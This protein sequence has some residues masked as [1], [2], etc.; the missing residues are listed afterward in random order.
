MPGQRARSG[1]KEIEVISVIPAISHQQWRTSSARDPLR[2]R[3]VAA[4]PALGTA[5][6]VFAAALALTSCAS[7]PTVE[8]AAAAPSPSWETLMAVPATEPLPG[9]TVEALQAVLDEWLEEAGYVGANAAVVSAE[10]VWQGSAGADAE[11]SAL[12]WDSALAVGSIAKTYTAAAVMGLVEDGQVDLDAPIDTYVE[13]PF[14]TD[15]ATVRQVL[16]MRSGFP[17]DRFGEPSLE[18]TVS[19]DLDRSW[20]ID[21]VLEVHADLQ[22]SA[23]ELGGEQ[24]YS[25]LNY[26]ALG[27]LVESVTGRSMADVVRAELMDPAGLERTWWQDAHEP[28]APLTVGKDPAGRTSVDA[29]GPWMPS[30]AWASVLGPA[31]GLASTAADTARWGYLLYGGFLLKPES[32]QQMTESGQPEGFYCDGDTCWYGLGTELSDPAGDLNAVGHGGDGIAYAAWLD[33]RQQS[34]VSIALLVPASWQAAVPGSRPLYEATDS[35]YE[36]LENS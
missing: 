16:N 35:L 20:S 33:V 21:E 23:G 31:G 10:G 17:A 19:S 2:T 5:C 18:A 9:D 3:V 32:V 34:D 30:R 36:V 13:L 26:W 25:N 15:G 22:D 1:P 28:Q 6:L 7:D 14:E 11:G 29:D 12:A 8:A 27:A 4:R 24:Q